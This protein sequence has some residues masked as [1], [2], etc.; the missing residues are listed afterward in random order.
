MQDIYVLH[1]QTP[2]V[3]YAVMHF[4]CFPSVFNIII[5]IYFLLQLDCAVR[6]AY[7]FIEPCPP[8]F[9]ALLLTDL[10]YAKSILLVRA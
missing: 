5:I 10:F 4:I 6:R 3:W 9:M 7:G 1:V 2:H 8:I